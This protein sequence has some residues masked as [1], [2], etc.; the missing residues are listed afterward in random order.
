[1][2]CIPT[3]SPAPLATRST[4]QRDAEQ[5]SGKSGAGNGLQSLTRVRTESVARIRTESVSGLEAEFVTR[6]RDLCFFWL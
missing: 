1:M 6:F 3:S 5:G 4:P 2:K